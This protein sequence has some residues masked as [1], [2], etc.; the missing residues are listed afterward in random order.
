[1]VNADFRIYNYFTLGPVDE[2]GQQKME[3][4]VKGSVKMAI[5][6]TSQNVQNNILYHNAQYVGITHD[7]DINDTYFISYEDYKL[8]VLYITRT[9]RFKQVFMSKVV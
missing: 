3:E 9:G 5:Y 2:Y 6:P 1:M 4:D 7:K 8:K